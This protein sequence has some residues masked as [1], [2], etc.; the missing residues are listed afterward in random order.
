MQSYKPKA[1]FFGGLPGAGKTSYANLIKR[2]S[3]KDFISIN[4]DKF[5]EPLLKEYDLLKMQAFD[6]ANKNSDKLKKQTEILNKAKELVA[7]DIEKALK[8]RRNI[9][10]DATARSIDEITT[11]KNELN[12]LG[13]ETFFVLVTSD[14][15]TAIER[16]TERDRSLH[17]NTIRAMNKQFTENLTRNVYKNLF[18]NNY[19]VIDNNTTTNPIEFERIVRSN[20]PP[21]HELDTAN[22]KTILKIIAWT[23]KL[24][25]QNINL[26][27]K[28]LSNFLFNKEQNKKFESSIAKIKE[29]Y[30]FRV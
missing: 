21:K 4:S 23:E 25:A 10:I 24:K 27:S 13:Y 28:T 26:L 19:A 12:K 17:P 30:K 22:K 11:K 9:I 15:K 6:E 8:K 18:K 2:M 7:K 14:I 3:R 1:I 20:H 29:S 16:N 5:A